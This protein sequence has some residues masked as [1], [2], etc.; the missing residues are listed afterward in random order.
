M[1]T[2]RRHDVDPQLYLTQLLMNLPSVRLSDLT[3]WL[4]DEWKRRQTASPE[5][6]PK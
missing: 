5:G 2:C 1:S 4:P 3:E 6:Q